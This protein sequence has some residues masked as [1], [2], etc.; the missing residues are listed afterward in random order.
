MD[1][2]RA[3]EKMVRDQYININ[4]KFTKMLSDGMKYKESWNWNSG[5]GF[6]VEL[7]HAY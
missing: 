1:A 5:R 4:S 7:A 2:K 6:I 3:C